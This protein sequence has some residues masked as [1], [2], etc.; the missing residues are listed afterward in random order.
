VA[1]TR[2]RAPGASRTPVADDPT[3]G[4]TERLVDY[5]AYY[6]GSS[7]DELSRALA[8]PKAQIRDELLELE[9]LGLVFRSAVNR[10]S[11]W[12]VG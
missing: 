10:M 2:S 12:H 11:R 8:V 5:L 9:R 3:Q 7:A 6:D 1:P 4:L